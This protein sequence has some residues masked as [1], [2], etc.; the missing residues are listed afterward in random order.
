MNTVL[1]IR[2]SI[3]LCQRHVHFLLRRNYLH[4]YAIPTL[5]TQ[6]ENQELFNREKRSEMMRDVCITRRFHTQSVCLHG[7]KRPVYTKDKIKSR[8]R[9]DRSSVTSV[10]IKSIAGAVHKNKE[11]NPKKNTDLANAIAAAKKSGVPNS[12]IDR[13]LARADRSNTSRKPRI[14]VASGVDGITVLLHCD[15]Q[16]KVEIESLYNPLRK[17]GFVLDKVNVMHQFDHKGVITLDTT[18]EAGETTLDRYLEMGLEVGVEDVTMETD[19]NNKC[20]IQF[21]CEP[22]DL[23]MIC[24]KLQTLGLTDLSPEE[25]YSPMNPITVSR[26]YALQLHGVFDVIMERF[27]YVEDVT[28]NFEIDDEND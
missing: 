5:G 25:V 15:I 27:I 13:A 19:E 1:S 20:V 24:R 2:N 17:K 21:I 10:H 7:G 22:G 4:K 9:V 18:E 14:L 8:S 6:L 23:N 3:T 12:T 11:I 28:F 16:S 26:E